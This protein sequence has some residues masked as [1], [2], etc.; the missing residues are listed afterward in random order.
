MTG[1]SSD[2]PPLTRVKASGIGE[3]GP[4]GGVVEETDP[5]SPVAGVKVRVPAGAFKQ[6][7]WVSIRYAGILATPDYPDGFVPFERP[8]PTGSVII[9]VFDPATNARPSGP[10]YMEIVFPL[11]K[12]VPGPLDIAS[13]FYHDADA[14]WRIRLPDDTST[15]AL[16]VKTDRSHVAWSWGLVDMETIDYQKYVAPALAERHGAQAVTDV[17]AK[18]REIAAQLEGVPGGVDVCATLDAAEPILISLRD[19]LSAQLD[20]YQVAIDCGVC[21]VKSVEFKEELAE[22]IKLNLEALLFDTL[23]DITPTKLLPLKLGFMLLSLQAELAAKDLACDFECF[24]KDP[25]LLPML[26][27]LVGYYFSLA[28]LDIVAITRI[29]YGC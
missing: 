19:E 21:D 11:G 26:P 2:D 28:G 18:M 4:A 14:Q 12:L 8:G 13:A 3:I 17:E 7:W 1:C 23:A 20:L 15:D 16:T 27:S 25:M 29:Y 9:D 6:T 24:I 22:Y 5:T 10:L